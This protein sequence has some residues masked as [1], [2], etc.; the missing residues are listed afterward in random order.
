MGEKKLT[1]F[2]K[3]LH[4]KCK[5]NL[6]L[7]CVGQLG[8]I[9]QSEKSLVRFPLRACA[10]VVGSFPGCGRYERQPIDVSLSHQCFSHFF[11]LPPLSKNKIFEKKVCHLKQKGKPFEKVQH[12]S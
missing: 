4:L 1:K 3:N 12:Y 6:A 8:V 5:R 9:P 10:L 2:P 7:A 11:P